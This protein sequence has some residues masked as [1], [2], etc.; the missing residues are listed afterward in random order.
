MRLEAQLEDEAL[1]LARVSA[2]RD[3]QEGIVAQI[4]GAN[5]S[6]RANE[7]V[8]RRWTHVSDHHRRPLR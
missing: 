1:T 6:S 5:R 7:R 8:T 3:A 4:D 2:S